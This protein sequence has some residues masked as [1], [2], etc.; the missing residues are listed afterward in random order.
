MLCS[1]SR[2]DPIFLAFN[3]GFA[4]VYLVALGYALP[5]KAPAA[6]EGEEEPDPEEVRLYHEKTAAGAPSPLYACAPPSVW[7]LA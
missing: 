5:G 3:I 1:E 7:S 4:L 6:P 2:T